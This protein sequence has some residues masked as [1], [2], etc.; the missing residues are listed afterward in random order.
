[1][2]FRVDVVEVSIGWG[3]RIKEQQEFPTRGLAIEFIEEFNK[4]LPAYGLSNKYT[5]ARGPFSD[6]CELDS[7]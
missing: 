1:M 4:D 3:M 6:V 7:N 5:M 2:S